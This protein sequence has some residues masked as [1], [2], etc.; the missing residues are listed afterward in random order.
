MEAVGQLAG[1]VAH[2][3]NN[4]LTAIFG[5]CGM[6]QMK[7]GEESPFKSSIDLILKAAERAA[8]LTRSLLAFSRKQIM[9]AKM[10]NLNDIVKNV[11]QL[12]T[13]IIGEDIQ[14][15]IVCTEKPL[16]IFADGGQI[17]QVL[18]NLA[19]NA[20][21]AMPDGGI[22]TI[23][24]EIREIDE[25]FIQTH[26]FGFPGKYAVIS[27]SDT[28]IGMDAEIRKKIFEPF[29]TTKGIGKGTGLGLSIV[30]GVITQHNGYINVNS[31]PD[32]G[33]TFEIYFPLVGEEDNKND[34]EAPID[35]PRKG[36]ETVLVAEDDP[37]IRQLANLALRKF[38]YEVI[39]A[40]DGLD[41]MEK[42]QANCDNIDIVLMDMIMPKKNGKEAYEEIRKVR[43]DVKI[44]FMSGYSA[45]ILHNRGF[46]NTGVEVITKPFRPL[47]LAR[48]VRDVLDFTLESQGPVNNLEM[49]D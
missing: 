38:G 12:I 3:F 31:D 11:W 29:F 6:L 22:L 1:G 25:V 16:T 23:E 36:T 30:Y 26:G 28:G 10:V 8:N 41:V 18:M 48:K 13:R 20:R 9:S 2:D 21:D 44:L 45:E 14:W 34:D 17:E 33:T 46:L 15:K 32:K 7:M 19:A 27:I 37:Y 49:Q 35:D 42:F 39:L 4:I 40:N 5:Y 24:T 43:P 47:E